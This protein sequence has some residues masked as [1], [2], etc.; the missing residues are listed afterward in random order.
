MV[1]ASAPLLPLGVEVG[2]AD[3]FY[4]VVP[5]KDGSNETL[6]LTHMRQTLMGDNMRMNVFYSNTGRSLS[7]DHGPQ[8]II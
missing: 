2:A 8:R 7:A 1:M 3:Y 4:Q 5:D 6:T